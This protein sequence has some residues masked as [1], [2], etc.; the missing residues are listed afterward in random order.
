MTEGIRGG[1]EYVADLYRTAPLGETILLLNAI[2]LAW[3][4][5][6][7]VMIGID[8]IG[9]AIGVGLTVR[10]FKLRRRLEK[11]M[12]RHDYDDRLFD[13]TI[14]EWCNRQTARVVA[15]NYGCL[16]EYVALCE[17]NKDNMSFADLPNF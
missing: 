15:K 1:L 4:Y 14:S 16:D 2:P 6:N 7:P 10:Q 12:S 3:N 9:C 8:I 5:N 11:Y 17:D 13:L